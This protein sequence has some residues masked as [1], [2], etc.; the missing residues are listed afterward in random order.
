MS[1]YL[2]ASYRITDP[3]AFGDYPPKA[4]PTIMQ[5]G[6]EVL[7]ADF[8]S[9]VIEGE[10]SP[11]TVIVRFPSKDAAHEWYRSQAYQDVIGLRT[12]NTEGSMVLLGEFELPAA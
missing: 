10:P 8:E 7:A 1:A 12:E 9:E 3:Q 4:I 2:V 11:V 6:G 5:Y